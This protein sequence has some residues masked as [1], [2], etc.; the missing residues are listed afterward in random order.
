M[1]SFMCLP[2]LET[3]NKTAHGPCTTRAKARTPLAELCRRLSVVLLLA[4]TTTAHAETR[5]AIPLPSGAPL[6]GYL[7]KPAGVGPFAAVA[8]LHSCLG[9]PADRVAL[10]DKLARAGL[11]ALWVDDFGTRSLSET[12]SVEF[13]E[14]MADARAAAAFLRQDPKVDAARLAAVG[15]SQGGDTALRLATQNSGFRAAAAYYPPCANLEGARLEMPTLILV[16]AADEVTPAVDCRAF[17][18]GQPRA[19]LIVFPGAGHLFD[20]PTAAGGVRKFGMR[21][22]YQA[23]AAR[24]AESALLKFLA[25]ELAAH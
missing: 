10:A 7:T 24:A 4:L 14:A 12:C 20:D 8:L 18:S 19:R 2:C 3:P 6:V 21:F 13:P 11:V 9:L 25:A 5:V 22:E 15:F 16:G 17:A 23:K 1:P